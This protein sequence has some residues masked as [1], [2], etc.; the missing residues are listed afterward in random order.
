MAL[1]CLTIR[2]PSSTITLPGD[3]LDQPLGTI[4]QGDTAEVLISVT[5]TEVGSPGS[6]VVTLDAVGNNAFGSEIHRRVETVKVTWN[7]VECQIYAFDGFY[8]PVDNP[9]VVNTVKAGQGIPVK[10]SLGGDFG[11]DIFEAG[12]PTPTA[13]QAEAV[14]ACT[15]RCELAPFTWRTLRRASRG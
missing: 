4:Y 14:L 13:R 8:R 2:P 3:W 9:P 11:L 6:Q 1:P 10:F 12:Y 5:P 7:A 15:A